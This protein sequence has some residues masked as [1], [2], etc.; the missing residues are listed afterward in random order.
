MAAA[1][2]IFRAAIIGTGRI[3]GTYDDEI[4]HYPDVEL[5]G[6]SVHTNM[7]SVKPVAHAGAYQTVPGYRLIAAA[8]R[9]QERLHAFGQRYGVRALY[10]DYR[11]MLT[12]ERPDVVSICTR[13][14]EKCD[15]VLACAEAGVRAV[16]VE[17]AFATS[18]VEADAM[19]AACE[20]AGTFVA[21]HHPM[22]FSL[23]FRRLRQLTHD[24]SIGDL[25]AMTIYAT[26]ELIHG[27]HAFDL[28]RFLGGEVTAVLARVPDLQPAPG[29]ADPFAAT[30]PDLGGDAIFTLASGATAFLS[31]STARPT[32][33]GVEV[34]GSTG[35]VTAPIW[36]AGAMPLVRR[37]ERASAEYGY[38]PRPDGRPVRPVTWDEVV[39]AWPDSA[40]ADQTSA[41][42]LL[43]RELHATL[44]TGAPFISTGRD[45]A[46]ALELG[47][48]FYHSALAHV[49]VQ[50]PLA[51]RR[52]RVINR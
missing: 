40:A 47:L 39:P 29:D 12:A 44:T 6:G 23:M 9:G 50:V 52:L 27:T 3:A 15:A 36:I 34:R 48:A 10:T 22:R 32:V 7:Y 25:G 18:M 45:G 37:R 51:E 19:L 1:Q 30:Y 4:I 14:P 38:G 24:G 16:I 31:M 13:S 5:P 11:R 33:D 20:Q 8:S 21:M 42:Q 17:K 26:G 2:P 43:L 28:V 46:L 41:I 49:P 35:Y